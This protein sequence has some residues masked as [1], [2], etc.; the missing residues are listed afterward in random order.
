MQ[1]KHYHWINLKQIVYI[2]IEKKNNIWQSQNSMYIWA[3]GIIL[4]NI[5]LSQPFDFDYNLN[6]MKKTAPCWPT[7]F[8]VIFVYCCTGNFVG[9]IAT[10]TFGQFKFNLYFFC[11]DQFIWIVVMK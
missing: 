2:Y 1:L 11:F 3:L 7:N 8:I 9:A 10:F 6:S 4:Q 5:E